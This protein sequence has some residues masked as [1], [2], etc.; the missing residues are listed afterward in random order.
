VKN[1][2]GGK[3]GDKGRWKVISLRDFFSMQRVH[4]TCQLN[5]NGLYGAVLQH[6]D[7][8]ILIGQEDVG[9]I[10]MGCKSSQAKGGHVLS[11]SS[12]SGFATQPSSS[13]CTRFIKTNKFK[14]HDIP[15]PN[16]PH[17]H[18]HPGDPTVHVRLPSYK[19]QHFRWSV[20][21]RMK[22]MIL[23]SHHLRDQVQENLA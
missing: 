16:T 6:M 21:G 4:C 10:I 15:L 17:R 11:V 3:E 23:T 20:K 18:P 7:T 13:S 14:S 2:G 22:L 12:L 19:E 1:T 9:E 8:S 5:K